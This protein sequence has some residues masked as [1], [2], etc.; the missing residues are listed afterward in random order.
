MEEYRALEKVSKIYYAALITGKKISTLPRETI[1]YYNK[2][3]ES[4]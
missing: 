3:C 4:K 2:T 1:E